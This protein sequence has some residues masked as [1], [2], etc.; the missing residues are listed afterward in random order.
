MKTKERDKEMLAEH[1]LEVRHEASGTFLDVR[2]YVADFIQKQHSFLPHWNIDANVINFRDDPQKIIKDGAFIGYK[3]AG[4]V[5]FNPETRNYFV[6]KASA[7]WK[8]LIKNEHYTLPAPLRFGARTKFYIPSGKTFDEINTAMYADVFTD[9]ARLLFGGTEQDLSFTTIL[10]EAGF[11]VRITGGPVHKDEAARYFQFKS[12]YFEKCGLFLDIDYYRT[13]ELSH[14]EVPQL[15]H[16]ANE[17][18]WQ[19][20]EKIASGLGL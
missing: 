2:G 3:S 19:R 1:V 11:D 4:Y 14:A 7:F 8:F 9:K 6:D 5:V 12:I 17:L 20:A 13:V 15:L 18:M 16:D 10:K